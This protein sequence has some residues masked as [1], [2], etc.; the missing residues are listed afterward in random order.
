MTLQECRAALIRFDLTGVMTAIDLHDEPAFG[1][2]E[3]YDVPADRTL[4][5]EFHAVELP[6][7]KATP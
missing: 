3:I 1:T 4:A 7:A 6:C 2:A 5:S